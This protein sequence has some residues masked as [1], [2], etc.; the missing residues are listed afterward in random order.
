MYSSHAGLNKFSVICGSARNGF[1][2]LSHTSW[3]FFTRESQRRSVEILW[4]RH[5]V[6]PWLWKTQWREEE[7]ENDLL[8]LTDTEKPRMRGPK[9]APKIRKLFSHS[10]EDDVQKYVNT[11]CQTFTT[12]AGKEVSKAPKIH[13]LVTPLTLQRKRTRITEEKRRVAKS[14]AVAADYQKLLATKEQ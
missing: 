2:N 7:G 13:R 12:K 11:Y 14:K 4:V 10:K 6:L 8:G 1:A 5:L 3:A 9:R